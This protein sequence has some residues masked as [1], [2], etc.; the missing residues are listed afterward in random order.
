MP[1]LCTCVSRGTVSASA[2]DAAHPG[3][4]RPI[5]GQFRSVRMTSTH[6]VDARVSLG[7]V[8]THPVPRPRSLHCSRL[9]EVHRQGPCYYA[10]SVEP[11]GGKPVHSL[12]RMTLSGAIAALTL[13]GTSEATAGTNQ[14]TSAGPG[15]GA[16]DDLRYSADGTELWLGSATAGAFR[17]TD[18][19]GIW[20][21]VSSGIGEQAV[22]SLEQSSL[23]GTQWLA[24]CPAQVLSCTAG[25]SPAW[26]S[27]LDIADADV[28]TIA[29]W[30]RNQSSHLFAGAA[31]GFY[32]SVDAGATW[33]RV[34]SGF[35]AKAILSI[36]TNPH[37]TSEVWV[38]TYDGVF[39]STDDGVTFSAMN[40]GL[41]SMPHKII[42]SILFDSTDS[43]R[44]YLGTW[45]GVYTSTDSGAHWSR[46]TSVP[47]VYVSKMSGAATSGGGF[48][49]AAA[50]KEGVYS[51]GSSSWSQVRAGAARAIAIRDGSWMVADDLGGLF[52]STDSGANWTDASGAAARDILD[53]AVSG[54]TVYAI[55]GDRT[56][57]NR[58]LWKS[59]DFSGTWSMVN[60]LPSDSRPAS[61]AIGAA[62]NVFVGSSFP[63]KS[64]LYN[65]TD[66]GVSWTNLA[67]GEEVFDASFLD[68]SCIE[69]HPTVATKVGTVLRPAER[70]FTEFDVFKSQDSGVTWTGISPSLAG[71][72]F[73]G[74]V[75][76]MRGANEI[77]VGGFAA[78]SAATGVLLV[79]Q[80]GGATWTRV[81]Q[82]L[83]VRP[84]TDI[85]LDL[86]P[87]Q[88][89]VWISTE[90]QG[91]FKTVDGGQTFVGAST[92]L[93]ELNVTGLAK[94][95]QAPVLY[96]GTSAAGVFRSTDGG[97]TWTA[98][99][100]LSFPKV[101]IV[102]TDAWGTAVLAGTL[103]GGVWHYQF[104]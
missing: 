26:T 33:I 95:S 71:H 45:F 93:G 47:E 87:N 20:A 43:T 11:Q 49:V 102:S 103:G 78:D 38:G 72:K 23:D 58:A 12:L 37:S 61:A 101:T 1:C 82:A 60:T 85:V 59:T 55:T 88:T 67:A 86:M 36:E 50:T 51:K 65:S 96:A 57:S 25:S 22:V 7:R 28:F 29:R 6:L 81:G 98:V 18:E 66:G 48:A 32:R 30:S 19:G 31:N 76:R 17:S 68:F 13:L 54:T 77:W 2:T 74:V 56:A 44:L 34:T 3:P 97:A 8:S 92:G 52:R 89:S 21:R 99:G 16:V 27:L 4:S 90:G 63:G 24:A 70:G 53:V 73:R 84:V 35:G 14:W 46:E 75:M 80:N 15:T 9:T 94:A 64:A 40:V 5:E 10:P 42:R 41:E 83:I 62:G 79:S 91:V 39:K 69:A 104:Q 100:A